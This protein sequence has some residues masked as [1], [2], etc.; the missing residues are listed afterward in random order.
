MTHDAQKTILLVEDD[1]IIA[2]AEKRMIERF[3]YHV[4]TAH[5]GEDA[6]ELATRDDQVD[7]VLM[8]INLDGELDGTDAA[9]LILAQ[10]EI[11]IVFLTSHAEKEYVE[12]V[13][14]I[15]RYGY[16][17]KNSGEFVLQSSIEMAFNLFMAHQRM[18]EREQALLESEKRFR[19]MATQI[20]VGLYRYRFSAS[21]DRQ[22][23]YFSPRLCQ[24]LKLTEAEL[25]KG[26]DHIIRIFHPD[27]R[28]SLEQANQVAGRELSHFR[29][30]GRY[31]VDGQ[32]RHVLIESD[33]TE[34][35]NGDV[36][37]NGVF[38]DITK[39]KQTEIALNESLID[40]KLA[41]EI[42]KIG[43]WQFDPAEGV[44]VWSEQVYKIY[45]RDPTQ[46]PPHIDEYRQLYEGEH[47]AIF[48]NAIQTA[49]SEGKP[50][51]ITLRLKLPG[52]TE[53]WIR[54]ICQ[55]DPQPGPAGHFLRGT[56]QD[57]TKSKQ[58][59]DAL[60]KSQTRLQAILDHTPTIVYMKDMQGHYI[61]INRT[62]EKLHHRKIE[63]IIGK[64]SH[65]VFPKEVAD[66]FVA[67]DQKVMTT[68]EPLIV[69][70]TFNYDGEQKTFLAIRFKIYNDHS[71][72]QAICG[73]S[74]DI[75]D[76][77]QAASKIRNLLQEKVILL[78]E[79]HHRIKNNMETVMGLLAL[80]AETLH[81]PQ[82]VAA[83]HNA[84]SRM[85][86]MMVLYDK[87]YRSP[88][89]TQMSIQEYLAALIDSILE[90]SPI[91][92][93]LTIDQNVDDFK[94]P[95]RALSSLG[96]IVNEL[97][98]NATKHAFVGRERGSIAVSAARV[99]GRVSLIVQDDGV[100]LPS[101]ISLADSP[102]FGLQLVKLMAAQ[103]EGE[104]QLDRRNGTRIELTFPLDAL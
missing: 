4:R 91:R 44:P 89:F 78:Q 81:H 49:I 104:V 69:E 92:K 34:M 10:R 77:I 88:D 32:V 86:S 76:R 59:E 54:A 20:P 64:T 74:T 24:M 22:I 60:R 90:G 11:P 94:L 45:E 16:V 67:S 21:N 12:R 36:I 101:H 37:W 83:L 85:K 71:E 29:W 62:C 51:D 2:L 28:P 50:Y 9:Q 3:G 42:A 30:E 84:R 87:L 39:M 31:I 100:G 80:Q 56:I 75:T 18:Q 79:V 43:N 33:P 82:A 52:V 103:L 35:D 65:E 40:L 66:Q 27:D 97:L 25:S 38:S 6:V 5:S 14:A 70:E 58:I 72:P 61:L 26:F 63:D 17:I 57:V 23:E 93:R 13:K 8:D 73:I 48:F 55:P 1:R 19:D 102:G 68:N 96:I 7:L 15:T 98:S 41:Q 47:Y 53:K 46:G 99:E 95:A